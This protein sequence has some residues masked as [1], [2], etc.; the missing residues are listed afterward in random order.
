[1]NSQLATMVI[2]MTVS[3]KT[4]ASRVLRTPR[5]TGGPSWRP[6]TG[7]TSSFHLRWATASAGGQRREP[8]SQ[9]RRN[10]YPPARPAGQLPLFPGCVNQITTPCPGP[11][12]NARAEGSRHGRT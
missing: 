10:S 8:F 3:E 6:P 4:K 12:E 1:M 2:Q 11:S 7:A 9:H 5:H